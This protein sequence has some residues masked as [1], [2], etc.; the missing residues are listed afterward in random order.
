[1]NMKKIPI[2]PYHFNAH[3]S[4]RAWTFGDNLNTDIIHPP[5]FYSLDPDKVKSGLFARY[6]K[7]I[8]Q[9]LLKNDILIGG[10]NFGCGS[11]RETSIR[12]LKLNEV[13][14]IIAVN[15]ARIFFRNATNCGLP[16]LQFSN[17]DDKQL[18]EQSELLQLDLTHCTLQLENG[19][20]IQLQDVGEFVKNIWRKGGLMELLNNQEQHPQEVA[21]YS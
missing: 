17:P 15:F 1:M 11:S 19:H 12:S 4:G 13:G 18:V 20:T 10:S 9:R 21:V 14:A 16:C 8:Q 2:E 7:T 6:D 3:I 5:D